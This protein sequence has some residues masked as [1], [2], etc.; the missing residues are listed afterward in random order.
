MEAR[1][2]DVIGTLVFMNADATP[3]NVSVK[4]TAESVDSIMAWYGAYFAGDRYTAAFNGRNIP[5]NING[6]CLFTVAE[7]SGGKDE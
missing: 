3:K 7:L 2:S 6:E 4:C 1:M 5:M